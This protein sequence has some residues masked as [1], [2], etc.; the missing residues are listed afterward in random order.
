M[1]YV[2]AHIDC[3]VGQQSCSSV[4][5]DELANVPRRLLDPLL[6]ALCRNASP[7][8]GSCECAPYP[9]ATLSLSRRHASIMQ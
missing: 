7:R 9:A 6:C 8:L 1:E 4:D 2:R 5:L 3:N